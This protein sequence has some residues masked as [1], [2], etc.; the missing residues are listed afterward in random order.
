MKEFRWKYAMV[1]FLPIE[2]VFF[3][4]ISQ[5]K[6]WVEKYYIPYVFKNLTVFLRLVLGKID[7]SI[8]L[9][10]FYITLFLLLFKVVQTT[11][12]L[13]KVKKIKGVYRGLLIKTFAILGV[14]FGIYMVIITGYYFQR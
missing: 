2:V 12:H 7:F 9:V 11:F 5:N 13:I 4:I 14:V 3:Y 6:V 8:G 1:I 10:L